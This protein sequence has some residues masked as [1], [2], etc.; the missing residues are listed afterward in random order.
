MFSNILVQLLT[1]TESVAPL[2]LMIWALE[3]MQNCLFYVT[4]ATPVL[5]IP[6]IYLRQPCCL[7]VYC[8]LLPSCITCHPISS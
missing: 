7:H 5:F 3:K 6:C 4:L 2:D 1:I 8:G